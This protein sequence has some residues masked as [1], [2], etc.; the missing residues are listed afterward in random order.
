MGHLK[1]FFASFLFFFFVLGGAFSQQL[2][3]FEK[4]YNYPFIVNDNISNDV[5]MQN[6]VNRIKNWDKL[7]D[8]SLAFTIELKLKVTKESFNKYYLYSE[9]IKKSCPDDV[10]YRN[11]SICSEF[12]PIGV[13]FQYN[14]NKGNT[15]QIINHDAR[16]KL[17]KN[18]DNVFTWIDS[19]SVLV[20]D[21]TSNLISLSY[22]KEWE[23]EITNKMNLID[24]YYQS[25]SLINSWDS[26]VNSIRFE[27][28]EMLPINDFILDE[29]EKS[30]ESFNNKNIITILEANNEK[31]NFLKN[32]IIEIN[33][34]VSQKRILLTEYLH[35][36]DY[37]FI[38]RAREE[39]KKVNRLGAIYNYNKALEYNP[40]SVQALSELARIMLDENRIVEA[41]EL[42]KI[43][44]SK[45][46]P[47]G[48]TYIECKKIATEV[49]N[50]IITKGNLLLK[51]EEFHRAIE[52]YSMAYIFCDSIR[53]PICTNEFYQGIV[54]SKYGILRSY[55]NVINK[56]LQ[57]DLLEIAEN[58]A[59]EAKKYQ[60]ANQK[61]IP[62]DNEIQTVVDKIVSKYV[63]NAT[64]N[65]EK[66]N[67]EVAIKQ[68]QSADSLGKTF[69]S[70]F[71]LKYLDDNLKR[72]YNGAFNVALS[73]SQTAV[74]SRN[75]FLADTKY[76]EAINYYHQ[77][78]EWI[79]DTIVGYS[80]FFNIRKLEFD[81]KVVLGNKFYSQGL[82]SASLTLLQDAKNI[83][84]TYKLSA[85]S[86]LDSLLLAISKPIAFEKLNKVSMMIWRNEL[87]E[88]KQIIDE[89]EQLI[90]KSKLEN[91]VEL[92]ELFNS[93]KRKFEFQECDFAN[94]RINHLENIYSRS[95]SSQSFGNALFALDSILIIQNTFS[96]C[97][98][99]PKSYTSEFETV[100][101]AAMYESLIQNCD[102]EFRLK[103]VNKAMTIYFVADS[104]YKSYKMS[105]TSV[106]KKTISSFFYQSPDYDLI[107]ES[108]NWLLSSPHYENVM[109]LLAILDRNGFSAN[110]TRNI[111]KSIAFKLRN[112]DKLEHPSVKSMDL[113]KLYS[114]HSKFYFTFRLNYLKNP[115]TAL[116]NPN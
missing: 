104:V 91:N 81:E 58:Y 72:A 15:K 114:V 71:S 46:W 82:F 69:R 6:V 30:I 52:A 24:L 88:S 55:F 44:F 87:V 84:T 109:P 5:Y 51:D 66:G 62:D 10:K 83:E 97:I 98:D 2:I 77:H 1:Y 99:N 93:T 102:I 112:R 70:N 115:I 47:H 57:R 111:Q 7:N 38:E 105:E 11:F 92:M 86:L 32:K 9:L 64:K 17:D 37:R 21:L 60:V 4:T 36:I 116:F 76:R 18:I 73:E 65:I 79:S 54:K 16:L 67:Y 3:V 106:Y 89:V 113:L 40:L 90:V 8:L 34:K 19:N 48:K 12:F 103:N 35:W 33:I 14:L 56:A 31:H 63:N 95:K 101:P 41:S 75:V 108:C 43:I 25:D 13:K 50:S 107:I 27:E 110:K 100:R 94:S 39:M 85:D 49:Y 74:N 80:V 96:R 23:K 20:V 29:V 22:N 78:P 26:I 59:R 68:I 53:E 42:I 45:T 28:I 61:E